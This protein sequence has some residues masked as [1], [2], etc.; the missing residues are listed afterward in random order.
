MTLIIWLLELHI[1][2]ICVHY[3]DYKFGH[4]MGRKIEIEIYTIKNVG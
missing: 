2:I 1:K 3:S 4:W